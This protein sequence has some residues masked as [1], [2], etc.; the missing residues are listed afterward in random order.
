M[1]ELFFDSVG[2]A[3]IRF[4]FMVCIDPM[5]SDKSSKLYQILVKVKE[6]MESGAEEFKNSIEFQLLKKSALALIDGVSMVIE[7]WKKLCSYMGWSNESDRDEVLKKQI[8]DSR[9]KS[10]R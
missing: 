9:P 3:A 2:V 6:Q 5:V 10:Y 7:D 4:Y 1:V 8:K